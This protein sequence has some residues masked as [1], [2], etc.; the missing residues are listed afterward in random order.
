MTSATLEQQ[1]D[2][3]GPAYRWLVT[4][5]GMIGAMS[6]VLSA[7]MVNVA[8]PSI[9]GAYGVGQD[10]AQWAATA[11][12]SSMVA[13]QL[14]NTWVVRAFGQ[15]LAYSLT[16]IIFT[17]GAVIC[18]VS[19]TIEVLI[20]GRIMQ[21]FS[22]GV[23]QPLVMATIISVFPANRRGFAMGLYGMGVTLAPSF[24]PLVGGLTIDAL[25]WRHIFIAPIPLVAIAF[26]MGL[27]FM[28]GKKFSRQLPE[29][30]WTGFVLLATALVCL[31]AGVG[32]GQRWGWG[33]DGILGLFF[34][35]LCASVAFV[36]WQAHA[37]A[38]LLDLTLFLNPR[39]AAA[40]VIAFAFG[41]G[42]FATNYAIPVFT[43]AVQGFTPTKAGMVLVPAGLLLVT[44]IPFSGR[45]ADR[46]PPHLPIMTGVALFAF[47]AYLLSFSDVNTPFLMIAMFAVLSRFGLGLVMPNMGAAAMRTVPTERLNHAAGAY[48]FTRQLGGAFGVNC[49]VAISEYRTAF[50]ADALTATQTPANVLSGEL[51]D[52]V[53]RVLSEQGLSEAA[54]QSG[55]LNYLSSV[56]HAQAITFGFQDAFLIICMV[57]IATLIPAWMLKR[58]K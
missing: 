24:G 25:T 7:T 13:S 56:I 34:I 20:I 14:L 42:N 36:Y 12:I 28:P 30:D 11:F 48:N 52:K 23:I 3:Y 35:G 46:V 19:P 57:F 21:G 58:T 4:I 38:P 45:L 26:A 10:M 33:S 9:M 8:V 37:K 27:V 44:M 6:M 32:N 18:V 51:I 22:A 49:V 40:M 43:Q 5:A 29:F 1:F 53:Q 47:A 2:R 54:Q 15:R 17:I 16:L 50:H 31:M 39:F 41:A 55:A